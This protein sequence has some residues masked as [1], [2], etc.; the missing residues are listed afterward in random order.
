MALFLFIP[1]TATS[2]HWLL[3][4]KP[5]ARLVLFLPPWKERLLEK[6]RGSQSRH[7]WKPGQ[8][9]SIPPTCPLPRALG[10]RLQ[11]KTGGWAGSGLE[12]T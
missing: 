8:R 4:P 7:V 3:G 10:R 6:F 11:T 1:S 9:Q 2:P 5:R 12:A